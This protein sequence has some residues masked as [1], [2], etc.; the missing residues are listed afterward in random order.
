MYNLANLLWTMISVSFKSESKKPY[1]SS[2]RNNTHHA[3][4]KDMRDRINSVF[5]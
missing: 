4:L 1:V 5:N 3:V 2:F